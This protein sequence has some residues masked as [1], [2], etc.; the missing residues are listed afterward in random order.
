MS[1][2]PSLLMQVQEMGREL[3]LQNS[4]YVTLKTQ[5]EKAKIDEVERD[6]M[7]QLID[8]PNIPAKLTRPRRGLSVTLALFFGIF[9]SIFTIY[10]K[11]HLLESD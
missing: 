5:H 7:V 3:D 6:D 10:F 2:S 4:L 9:L 1:S 11:E 8:G